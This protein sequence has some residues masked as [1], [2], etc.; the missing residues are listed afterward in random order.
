[1]CSQQVAKLLLDVR[2]VGVIP[3]GAS[4]KIPS[5]IIGSN[6]AKIVTAFGV[7]KGEVEINSPVVVIGTDRSALVT[8]F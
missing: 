7:L 4:N 2:D 1:M 3:L 6:D 8:T 5:W